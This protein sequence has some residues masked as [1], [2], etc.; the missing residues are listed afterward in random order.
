MQ[1]NLH[2]PVRWHFF[3]TA[4]VATVALSV[5]LLA[6]SSALAA[7]CGDNV[8]GQRVACSCGDVLVSSA[9]LR[10]DDPVVAD[11]PCSHNG[12]TIRAPRGAQTVTLDLGGNSLLGS[13]LGT[14]VN[15]VSG[16][17][18]GA[19]VRGGA[20]S[21]IVGFTYGLRAG[22][23]S[24]LARVEDLGLRANRRDGLVARGDGV[25]LVNVSSSSNGRHGLDLGGNNGVLR[26][27][28]ST[29]NLKSGARLA[30][31]GNSV[32]ADL[33]GNGEQSR[34]RASGNDLSGVEN[35]D[36]NGEVAR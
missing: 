35:D 23:R 29:G 17:V 26:G 4:G 20:G 16:G 7:A 32:Q 34:L 12:L 25:E 13:G 22:G 3:Y 30:G 2:L 31:T 14:G 19:L 24:S 15:V 27:V 11:A 36:S 9:T 28:S 10:A 33:A 5:C 8:G 1:N 18:G 6:S 21:E